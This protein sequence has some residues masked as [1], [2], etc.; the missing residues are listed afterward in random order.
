[1]SDPM[2]EAKPFLGTESA[3]FLRKL[4]KSNPDKAKLIADQLKLLAIPSVTAASVQLSGTDYQISLLPSGYRAVFRILN[5]DEKEQ[6]NGGKMDEPAV[7]VADILKP[8]RRG[9]R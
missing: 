7:I 1:M 9:F 4:N 2:V 5:D 3:E 8:S 6:M